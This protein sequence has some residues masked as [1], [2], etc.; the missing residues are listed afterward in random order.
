MV[1]D[2]ITP[3]QSWLF[4]DAYLKAVQVEWL[5]SVMK[6]TVEPSLGPDDFRVAVQA[7]LSGEVP[8]TWPPLVDASPPKSA[9]D[10]HPPPEIDAHRHRRRAYVRLRAAVLLLGQFHQNHVLLGLRTAPSASVYMCG[11]KTFPK[12]RIPL[13]AKGLHCS[14]EWL[15]G[16]DLVAISNPSSWRQGHAPTKSAPQYRVVTF[17]SFA[18]SLSTLDWDDIRAVLDLRSP[19]PARMTNA[20]GWMHPFMVLE[21]H[22]QAQF[23]QPPKPPIAW[24]Y[25]EPKWLIEALT[26]KKKAVRRPPCGG[27]RHSL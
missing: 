24:S 1:N 26:P 16:S 10:W 20:P 9:E 17:R 4:T 11:K 14:S 6:R 2:A 5:K 8:E 25:N 22:R 3:A 21:A 27:R 13:A 7:V 12:S 15:A 18:E 19:L 23:M